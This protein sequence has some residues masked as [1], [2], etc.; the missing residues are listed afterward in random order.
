MVGCRRCTPQTEVADL[1]SAEDVA[2]SLRRVASAWRFGPGPNVCFVDSEPF[3]HPSLPEIIGAAAQLGFER[4]RLRTDAGALSRSGNAPGVLGAG[5]RHL[6]V[7]LLGDSGSH[8]ALTGREGLFGM[9]ELGVNAFTTAAEER[10]EAVAV[11]ALIPACRHNAALLPEAVGAA[12]RIGAC[13][14]VLEASQLK[15]NATN[16][17]LVAAALQTATVNRM[18]GSVRGGERVGP[19][20]YERAPWDSCEVQP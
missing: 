5:V 12:A 1:Y 15:R 16:A 7:V 20:V 14:V 11:S 10:G 9:V 4:I 2:A 6:E 3:R 19:V 18:A 8:D 17:A 13:A